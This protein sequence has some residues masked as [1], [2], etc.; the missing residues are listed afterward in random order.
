M[1]EIQIVHLIPFCLNLFWFPRNTNHIVT[2][3]EAKKKK[4]AYCQNKIKYEC[5]IKYL[6]WNIIFLS[7]SLCV[8][9][10]IHCRSSFFML[11]RNLRKALFTLFKKLFGNVYWFLIPVI[12]RRPLHEQSGLKRRRSSL[13]IIFRNMLRAMT[14]RI[15]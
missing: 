14:Q 9:K 8:H 6:L 15:I 10:T 4:L 13:K 3:N 1:I 11:Q 5:H 7:Q 12:N 2:W